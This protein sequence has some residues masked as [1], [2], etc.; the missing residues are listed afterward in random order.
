MFRVRLVAAAVLGLAVSTSVTAGGAVA[1]VQ[2][3]AVSCPAVSSSGV[4]TPAPVPGVDWSGCDLRGANLDGANL[5]GANL[6]GANLGHDFGNSA[7]TFSNA[8]LSSAEL[9]F[10]G[11]SQAIFEDATLAGADLFWTQLGD[12]DLT[13]ANVNGA[14]LQYTGM[15]GSVVTGATFANDTWIHVTCPDGTN[16]DS[17]VDGCF[18]AKDTTPPSAAPSVVSGTAGANGWYTSAVIVYWNWTD[19][20]TIQPADCTGSSYVSANGTTTLTAACADRA[21][22]IGHASFTVRVDTTAPAVVVTGV[23][24]RRQYVFGQVPAPGC[25]TS[26]PVSGVAR[27]AK[28]TV[29]TTGSSGVGSFTATCSGAVSVAGTSQA[30]PVRARYTVV[31]G[32]GGFMSPRPGSTLAKASRT[33]VATFRLTNAAGHSISSGRAR[34]VAATHRIRVNLKGPGI[35]TATAIC[36]WNASAQ[37]FRC[38]IKM[39]AG[40]RT[41]SSNRYA[42]TAFEN[43]GM[44]LQPVPPVGKAI[45]PETIYF[46]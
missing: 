42:I 12:A 17:Y 37:V 43:L 40:I 19:D 36:E 22:N 24:D 28:L 20:G 1:A 33:I 41:G 13:S 46:R 10:A 8:N 27:S 25:R 26:D 44:G 15:A 9:G 30:A 21:G 7:T 29:T 2:P 6:S 3:A 38:V 4:V 16:S 45:N 14:N 11:L 31:Y 5:S 23:R 32:F 18:S 39:P 34:Y 35:V